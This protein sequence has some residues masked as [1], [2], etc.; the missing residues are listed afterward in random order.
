ML[1]LDYTL[2]NCLFKKKILLT[3]EANFETVIACRYA[4]VENML[5]CNSSNKIK[6][7][8]FNYNQHKSDG[9]LPNVHFRSQLNSSAA[10]FKKKQL[11]EAEANLES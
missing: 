9:N 2:F 6:K 4:I 10:Q 8:N 1:Q 7:Y 3:A 11:L 5:K